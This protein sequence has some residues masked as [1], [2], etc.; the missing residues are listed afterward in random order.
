[1]NRPEAILFDLDGTLYDS[2]WY[3]IGA[4]ADMAAEAARITGVAA[5]P[6][7][8]TLEQLYLERTSSYA[9]HVDDALRAHGLPLS[10]VPALVR[11]HNGHVP[12]ISLFPGVR[13]LLESLSSDYRLGLVT[14]GNPG[15]Q[16]RKIATLLLEDVFDVVVLTGE[17]RAPKPSPVGFLRALEELGVAPE[18][19]MYVGDNPRVDMP[20]ARALGMGAVRVRTG[21]LA[22]VEVPELPS[23]HR[24][25]HDLHDLPTLL[26][27]P[28][29]SAGLLDR[30]CRAQLAPATIRAL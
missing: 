17:L 8:R 1:M 5:E 23:A 28:A 15:K 10:L 7:R 6:I 21:E 24:E 2:R 16:R 11:A 26:H 18:D 13:S 25:I 19:A 3:L 4:A 22:G 30:L 9:H 14:D 12:D 27:T 20:P 29:R